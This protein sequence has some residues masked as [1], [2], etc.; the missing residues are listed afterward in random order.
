MALFTGILKDLKGR[1]EV[2]RRALESKRLRVNVKKT[3][4]IISSQN[5]G[6]VKIEG[7]FSCAVCRRGADKFHPTPLL[8]A[9]GA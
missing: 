9:L 5:A 3:K 1:L 7:K 6:K 4:M 8:K 2:W